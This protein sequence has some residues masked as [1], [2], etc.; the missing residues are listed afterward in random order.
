[1]EN[2]RTHLKDMDGGEHVYECKPFAFDEAF[3]LGL[4][5]AGVVGGPIGEALKGLLLGSGL[6]DLELDGQVIGSIAS[7]LGDLPGRVAT[8]GGSELIARILKQTW[9]KG[10][11]SDPGGDVRQLLGEAGDRDNAFGRGNLREGMEATAWVLRVNY[12]PFLTGLWAVLRPQLAGLETLRNL[13]Q[14]PP[15]A[16]ETEHS[17]RTSPVSKPTEVVS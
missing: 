6:D 12:G 13:H 16:S 5:L 15:E 14:D 10:G 8:E 11:T 3:D 4:K 17:E 1:M 7:T 9:R 2:P